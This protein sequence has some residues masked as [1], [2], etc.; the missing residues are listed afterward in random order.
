MWKAINCFSRL[1]GG[2]IIMDKQ[3]INC[4]VYSCRHNEKN[5]TCSLPEI[6]V[7]S[8]ENCS[9]GLPDESMCASYK[10]K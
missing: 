9:S 1:L 2:R 5:Q 3:R 7:C 6:N 4:T 8:C 10:S